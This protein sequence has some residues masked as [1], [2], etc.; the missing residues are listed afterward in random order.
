MAARS[1]LPSVS[2]RWEGLRAELELVVADV[3]KR[4]QRK[5]ARDLVVPLAVLVMD[6]ERFGG[7]L[8][9]GADKTSADAGGRASNPAARARSAQPPRTAVRAGGA[10]RADTTPPPSRRDARPE[11]AAA[12]SIALR[13]ALDAGCPLV[14][15]SKR[16]RLGGVAAG[17]LPFR[18]ELQRSRGHSRER[19]EV[20]P[21]VLEHR[22]EGSAHRRCAGSG[23]TATESRDR[24]RPRRAS[25]RTAP[26]P[27]SPAGS[28]RRPR[29]FRPTRPRHKRRAGCSMSKC[30]T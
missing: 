13:G 22:L 9:Q 19:H 8:A 6:G 29:R 11:S 27:A 17:R 28:P 14:D 4:K 3:V 21:I 18:N 26:S 20:E 5:F 23:N 25:P 15:L 10:G 24:A 12:W 1:L 16:Q 30:R 2:G 7:E